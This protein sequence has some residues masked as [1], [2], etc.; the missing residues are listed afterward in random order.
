[1]ITNTFMS[2]K[3]L[4]RNIFY[5][6]VVILLVYEY[7]RQNIKDYHDK[8][9]FFKTNTY[10]WFFQY[11]SLIIAISQEEIWDNYVLTYGCDVSQI[12][13][14]QELWLALIVYIVIFTTAVLIPFW[15]YRTENL[16]GEQKLI[17]LL[18]SFII[19]ILFVVGKRAVFF[20]FVNKTMIANPV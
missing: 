1:M 13:S 11:V 17:C 14:Q 8:I 7:G 4:F 2:V 12:Y 5:L 10:L 18:I 6:L 20:N 19:I 9:R 15:V 3:L 16:S